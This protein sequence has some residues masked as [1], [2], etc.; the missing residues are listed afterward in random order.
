MQYKFLKTVLDNVHS[1]EVT[2]EFTGQEQALS[3]TFGEP[4]VNFGGTIPG[5]IG[6]TLPDHYRKINSG[7]PYSFSL[8]ANGDADAKTKMNEWIAEMIVRLSAAAVALRA[9][10]DDFTGEQKD[11]V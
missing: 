9:Q 7:L 6:M 1:S 4:E 3:T 8:D 10:S 2:T 5:A 11:T